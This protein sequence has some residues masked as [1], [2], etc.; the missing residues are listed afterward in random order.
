MIPFRQH[1]CTTS[2]PHCHSGESTFCH[3]HLHCQHHRPPAAATPQ[4]VRLELPGYLVPLAQ[5]QKAPAPEMHM[6]V[7]HDGAPVVVARSEVP[8]DQWAN[9]RCSCGR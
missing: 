7:S 8:T 9:G 4:Q 3:L 6:V 2:H 5:S 1:L